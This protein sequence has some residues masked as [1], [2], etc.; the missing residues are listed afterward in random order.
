MSLAA[1]SCVLVFVSIC[2]VLTELKGLSN[3]SN[4]NS[5]SMSDT[6]LS[7]LETSALRSLFADEAARTLR[8]KVTKDT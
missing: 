3:S 6:V 2:L 7:A 5:S 1:S 8:G 4:R